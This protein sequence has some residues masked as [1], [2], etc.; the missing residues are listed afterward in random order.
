MKAEMKALIVGKG[1]IGKR[2]HE[3]LSG[4]GV[5]AFFVS[6]HDLLADNTYPSLP[7]ALANDNF[8]YVIVANRTSE[9]LATLIELENLE[10]KGKCLV[11]K[12]LF[13]TTADTELSFNFDIVVGYVLRFNPMIQRLLEI[14]DGHRILSV[15]A[16]CG[17]YLP[18]WRS[19][20]DYRQCYSSSKLLGGGALRDLSHELDYLQYIT[21]SWKR[22]VALGGKFSSLEIDSD[23]QNMILMESY[24]GSMISCHVNYL[25]R[26]VRR[27]CA[28]EYEGGSAVIDFIGCTVTHN[29]IVEKFSFQRNDM[30]IKMHNAAINS[31]HKI[32]CL[33]AEAL[34]TMW[35]IDAIEKSVKEGAWICCRESQ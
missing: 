5:N 29:K 31:N 27:Y 32:I 8:D 24:S 3:V 9:H 35:L 18:E 15:N 30:F 20:Q 14:V 12:P 17:Q 16:Y 4:L 11:E 33:Y 25:D 1:S 10:F 22:V 26:N 23:D 6:R 2:H 34:R 7:E 19:G 13:I 21:G 28:V